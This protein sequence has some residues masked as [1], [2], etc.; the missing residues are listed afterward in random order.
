MKK[1]CLGLMLFALLVSAARPAM[2]GNGP[3]Q[4]SAVSVMLTGS[5]V[6]AV[7]SIPLLALASIGDASVTAIKS[8]GKNQKDITVRQTATGKT[9]VVRVP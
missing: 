8:S 7:S 4:A 2:A 5:L 3:S 1:A 9:A 6:V